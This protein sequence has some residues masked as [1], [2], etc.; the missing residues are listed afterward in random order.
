MV[1]LNLGR[2]MQYSS[3]YQN[4]TAFT[5]CWK[6]TQSQLG[7]TLEVRCHLSCHRKEKA[8]TISQYCRSA[9][10][11]VA[12]CIQIT[13]RRVGQCSNC[14]WQIVCF[15]NEP[16]DTRQTMQL[17]KCPWELV[18]AVQLEYEYAAHRYGYSAD[19]FV[20]AQHNNGRKKAR[21]RRCTLLNLAK[22]VDGRYL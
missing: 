4:S 16:N 13:D 9:V 6:T 18:P 7:E 15:D 19:F 21:K 1:P 8:L 14:A 17:R 20:F 3:T 10:P 12:S 5:S 11:V 2:S 22:N